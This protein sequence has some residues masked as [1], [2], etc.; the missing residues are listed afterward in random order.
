ML[1]RWVIVAIAVQ[2]A[3]GAP[4]LALDRRRAVTQYAHSHYDARDG[5]PHSLA[6]SIAQTPDGYLWAGSEEG[7]ARFDG[8][9]FTTF[10]HR[11][12]DG[13]PANAFSAL[14]VDAAG[15]LWAGTREHG[16]LH[17]VDGEF[18]L[19]VWEPGA[20]ALQIRTLAFDRSGDLWVGTRGHGLVQLQA[21]RL[22]ATL[23]ADNGLPSN[24]IRSLRVAH[25]GTLWIGTFRGL[26]RWSAGRIQHG[27]PAL[28]GVAVDSIAEDV[29]GVLWCA[30]ANGL[31][32]VV[33]DTVALVGDIRLPAGDLHQLLFDRDGNLWIGTGNGVARRTPDGRIGLLALPSSIVL[34]LFEDAEA[35]LWI[36]SEKGLDRL[37]D[38]D[39]VPFGAAE[40]MTD[41]PVFGVREDPTGALWIASSKGLLRL[42]PGQTTAT[43]ITD[44]GT[45]YAIYPDSHGDIWFGARD[46]GVGRWHDGRFAWLGRRPWERVRAIAET[47]EGMWFGTNHGLF[48]L[49]GDQLDAAEAVLPGPIV[50]AILPDA[51]GALW[52]GAEGQGLL[53]WQGGMLVPIPPDGPPATSSVVTIQV[54]ADGTLWAGTEGSGLW[55]LRDGRWFAF[56]SK[57]GMF[58]DLVWRIL[59]DG[60]GNLWMSSNRG[61]WRVSREQLEAKAAGHRARIDSVVYGEADG[62]RDR[63]CNGAVEPAGWRTRDGRL[64]FPTGKG[65][66]MFDP[67]HL[68]QARPPTA[69]IETV[70]VD[71]KLQRLASSVTLLPGSSRLEI[72]YTAPALA[73]PERLRFHYRLDG[74][75]RDWNDAGA[76]RVAQYTNLSPGTYRFIVEAGSD[77]AWGTGGLLTATLRPLFY[78]TR[79]F[80]AVAMVSIVLAIVSVPLLRV[81]QLRA[82]ARELDHRVQEAIREL[83]VLSG[84]LPICAWCKKIRDDRG[85]W[86]KIEAYLGARTDAQFTHGICPDCDAKLAAEDEASEPHGNPNAT[87]EPPPAASERKDGDAR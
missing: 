54:D 48:R 62:M 4:A 86:S 85:Y 27:P 47:S 65:L 80:A 30:T 61:I 35:N 9:A 38:G 42:A 25:D 17:L 60:R 59:D 41:E 56:T 82:R 66:A 12:T 15:T 77:G 16:L 26:A 19:V 5:M 69:L 37:R 55:R 32:R 64:W 3:L 68:H 50:S 81:R 10:D 71:G 51:S 44:G 52:L 39:A 46:G 78:Q 2:L 24:D 57:D 29:D 23:T 22:I 13:I 73:S 11:K 6:N 83:K 76:Q 84:L 63:E 72:G 33:G 75:D 79:W 21:G 36:A 31:A 49:R 40:G 58:D 45:M 43:T 18:H 87:G 34:A 67:E 8:A 1:P 70:R 53:R 20:E 14:A 28:D 7:L 74:F